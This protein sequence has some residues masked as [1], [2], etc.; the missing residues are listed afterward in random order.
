M[1][2]WLGEWVAS[3]QD[4]VQYEPWGNCFM[5]LVNNGLLGIDCLNMYEG[6]EVA[7]PRP[8]VNRTLHGI[9]EAEVWFVAWSIWCM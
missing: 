5:R 7:F 8:A 2:S 9:G 3:P 4:C 6:E 1:T